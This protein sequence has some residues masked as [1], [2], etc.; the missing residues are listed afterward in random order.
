MTL[1]LIGLAALVF[2]ACL[3]IIG[4]LWQRHEPVRLARKWEERERLL[5]RRRPIATLR[6]ILLQRRSRPRN[7]G[8]ETDGEAG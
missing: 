4:R 7:R 5:D 6:D 1:F 8:G 2:A 3:A